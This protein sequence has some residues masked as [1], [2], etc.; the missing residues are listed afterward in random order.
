[1]SQSKVVIRINVDSHKAPDT[2]SRPQELVVWH[3]GRIALAV[4]MLVAIP[5]AL[6]AVFGSGHSGLPAPVVQQ[7]VQPV[8]VAAQPVVLQ[9]PVVVSAPTPIM[10]SVP[11]QHVGVHKR[12][13]RPAY[14]A[15]IYNK[16]VFR[17]SLN[18]VIKDNEPFEQPR[19]PLKLS[20][21]KPVEIFYF[22]EIRHAD[23]KPLFHR[24]N[25]D[26]QT[27]LKKR[28]PI[29]NGRIKVVSSRKFSHNDYGYWSV[30]L[31]D[32]SGK[33]YSEVDFLAESE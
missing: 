10:A 7:S 23:N 18:T 30:Q 19:F 15:V 6:L 8:A 33:I 29:E 12:D 20:G 11:T 13:D 31:V 32:A 28:L 21:N 14:N 27:V 3:K 1:M 24:W 25:R 2:P 5:V 26:G 16:K 17:A 22:N 4:A 9:T